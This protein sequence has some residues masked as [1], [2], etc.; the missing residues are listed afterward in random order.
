M[1]STVHKVMITSPFTPKKQPRTEKAYHCPSSN[2][3]D[4]KNERIRDTV[5]KKVIE[6]M[7][8]AEK[9]KEHLAKLEEKPKKKAMAASSNGSGGKGSKY[10]FTSF[11]LYYVVADI[12]I[13]VLSLLGYIITDKYKGLTNQ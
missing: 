10:V 9:I 1:L 7:A 12:V 13:F 3:I 2:T 8:R 4:E 6:Y 5:R 11:Y